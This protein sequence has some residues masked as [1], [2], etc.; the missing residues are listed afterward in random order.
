M[1]LTKLIDLYSIK[2]SF[3]IENS[4][5]YPNY[6]NIISSLITILFI[7]IITFLY[8]FDLSLNPKQMYSFIEYNTSYN[9]KIYLSKE[10]F[11][12]MFSI[13]DSNGDFIGMNSNIGTF[14]GGVYIENN[15]ALLEKKIEF[16]IVECNLV[17]MIIEKKSEI[18][19]T[20]YNEIN[21]NEMDKMNCLLLEDEDIEILN[22]ETQ[23]MLIKIGLNI[24]NDTSTNYTQC[25]S[26]DNID[27]FIKGKT[28]HFH[29]SNYRSI[30]NKSKPQLIMNHISLPLNVDFKSKINIQL[31]RL[32]YMNEIGYFITNQKHNN[33]YISSTSY[34]SP[35]YN[36]NSLSEIEFSFSNKHAYTQILSNK[37]IGCICATIFTFSQMI[38]FIIHFITY[39]TNHLLYQSFLC[40]FFN[41]QTGMQLIHRLIKKIR[42]N[43]RNLKELTKQN[44]SQTSKVQFVHIPNAIRHNSNK[45]ITPSVDKLKQQSSLLNQGINSDQND[46]NLIKYDS[47]KKAKAFGTSVNDNNSLIFKGNSPNVLPVPHAQGSN[48][49]SNIAYV[50]SISQHFK[51]KNDTYKPI[52]TYMSCRK[53]MNYWCCFTAASKEAKDIKRNFNN[54]KLFFDVLRFIKLYNDVDVLRDCLLD[55]AGSKEIES[56]FSLKKNSDT[57]M[58]LYERN[59]VSAKNDENYTNVKILCDSLN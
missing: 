15:N 20:I 26:I 25:H 29:Y 41:E 59:F 54:I 53:I 28:I 18:T 48:Q 34:I 22:Y 16:Q 9:D 7:L 45:T 1:P 13:S 2:P 8:I 10:N 35:L 19:Q 17:T 40:S 43:A 46:S 23:R 27:Q 50:N 51:K 57:I 5:F 52:A 3:H 49:S 6:V 32:T 39:N 47:Q 58:E 56:C 37:K 31:N 55:D 38:Y 21:N 36:T 11:I 30:Y 42:S 33:Y 4:K 24:C 12:V 14:K 44:S